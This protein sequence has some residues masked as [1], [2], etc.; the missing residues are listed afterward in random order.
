M[1]AEDKIAK[2]TD[3]NIKRVYRNCELLTKYFDLMDKRL[4]RNKV[5]KRIIQPYMDLEDIIEDEIMAY[6]QF[7]VDQ[8]QGALSQL[9]INVVEKFLLRIAQNKENYPSENEMESI[10]NQI[11]KDYNYNS[12]KLLSEIFADYLRI[13]KYSQLFKQINDKLG[14]IIFNQKNVFRDYILKMLYVEDIFSEEEASDCENQVLGIL[15]KHNN[16]FNIPEKYLNNLDTISAYLSTCDIKNFHSEIKKNNELKNMEENIQKK[17]EKDIK[18]GNEIILEQQDKIKGEDSKYEISKLRKEIKN[19]EINFTKALKEEKANHNT[20]IKKMNEEI[21]QLKEKNII[22]GD[23][24]VNLKRRIDNLE[25]K[26]FKIQSRDILKKIVN[27]NLYHLQ[28]DKIGDYDE[29]I[30]NIIFK[31][32]SYKNSDLYIRFFQD[33]KTIINKGD[34]LAHTFEKKLPYGMNKSYLDLLLN[35]LSLPSISFSEKKTV[36]KILI[37]IKTEDMINRFLTGLQI[38][39]KNEKFDLKKILADL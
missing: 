15:K 13:E 9:V 18:I 39:D 35:N 20:E 28:I 25:D 30:Q 26:L 36:K 27:Y 5:E 22:F 31:L 32:R 8:R 1:K 3:D 14:I 29:R 38:I 10:I 11:G 33:I 16:Y 21:A 24:Q 19:F 7:I 6:L 4:I 2:E 37:N 17:E 23:N 34:S 12:N